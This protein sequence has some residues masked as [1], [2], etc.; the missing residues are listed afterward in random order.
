MSQTADEKKRPGSVPPS[1]CASSSRRVLAWPWL[2]VIGTMLG[3]G[4]VAEAQGS[5]LVGTVVDSAGK[6]LGGATVDVATL[7]RQAATDDSGVFVLVNLPMGPLEV[8]V[9]RLGYEPQRI[10]LSI[11]GSIDSIVVRMVSQ[12]LTLGVVSA[13]ANRQRIN[14]DA[15]YER[16]R[17]GMGT[18]VTRSEILARRPLSTTDMFRAAPGIRVLRLRGTDG[19]RFNS[20]SSMRRD[21]APMLWIDGQRAPGMELGEI[22]PGDVEGIE[23]YNGP[24]TTPMQFSH[25]PAGSACGV[26]VV[27]TRPPPPARP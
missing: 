22:P 8:S 15:F 2:L 9:R 4:S 23:L 1:P 20:S 11:S 3:G 14:I 17:R 16:V 5:R 10:A 21:C 26:V 18:Y 6:P 27:W 25:G 12:A 7:R 13:T 24:S 19:I